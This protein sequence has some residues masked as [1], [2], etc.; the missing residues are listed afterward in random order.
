MHIKLRSIT[1]VKLQGVIEYITI[2]LM[3]DMW[4][5]RYNG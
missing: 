1:I 4:K 5:R 2:E 3:A